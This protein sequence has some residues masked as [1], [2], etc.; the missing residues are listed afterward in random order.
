MIAVDLIT[1]TLHNHSL[2]H[3][4]LNKIMNH[5]VTQRKCMKNTIG[6]CLSK[7]VNKFHLFLVLNNNSKQLQTQLNRGN[8]TPIYTDS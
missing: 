4:P 8:K 7:Y 1:I 6:K 5:H 2:F 3:K